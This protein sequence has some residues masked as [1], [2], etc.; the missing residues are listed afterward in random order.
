MKVSCRSTAVVHNRAFTKK[1]LPLHT[2]GLQSRG[3][4]CVCARPGRRAFVVTRR[5]V[6]HRPEGWLT[7]GA[8]GRV[9]SGLPE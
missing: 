7:D 3:E 8:G 4:V 6:E 9:A 5:C 2:I 1:N